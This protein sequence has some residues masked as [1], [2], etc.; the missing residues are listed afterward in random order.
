MTKAK[1]GQFVCV[2]IFPQL[3]WFFFKN[4]LLKGC[5]PV[6]VNFLK[7]KNIPQGRLK[8]SAKNVFILQLIFALLFL[9]LLLS[10]VTY[11]FYNLIYKYNLCILLLCIQS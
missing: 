11:L 9:V 2:H 3:N 4:C 6:M 10:C 5:K 1:F 7:T 8:L